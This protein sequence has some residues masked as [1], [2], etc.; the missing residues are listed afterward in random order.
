MDITDIF[1]SQ[2]KKMRK[3]IGLSQEKLAFKA[4]LDR[5]YIA[6]IENKK[7]NVSIKTVEQIANALNI[8]ICTLLNKENK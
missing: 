2:T 5:T 6:S 1:A 8:D 4:N 7:R 3:E